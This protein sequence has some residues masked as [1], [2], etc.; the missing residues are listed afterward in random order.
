MMVTFHRAFD[1]SRDPFKAME[2]LISIGGI[3]R[4]LTSGQEAG[5]L[6]GLPLIIQL[7][8][9]AKGRIQIMPG[10]KEKGGKDGIIGI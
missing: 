2:D 6:E 10:C 1:M 8:D 3:E 7:I 9:C 4:I 5:V